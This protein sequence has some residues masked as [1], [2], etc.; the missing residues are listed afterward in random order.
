EVL[1]ELPISD[2]CLATIDLERQSVDQNRP[3]VVKWKVKRAAI[4][5]GHPALERASLNFERDERGIL[6]RTETPLPWI[7]D[8]LHTLRT[9][10]RV[11]PI[12]LE[13]QIVRDFLVRNKQS[14]L[15][16]LVA[17]AA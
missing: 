9:Q 1:A 5:Q 13:R 11:G 7:G 3:P 14:G 6:E 15:H 17:K 4:F 10:R 16:E 8:E 12:R 2:P